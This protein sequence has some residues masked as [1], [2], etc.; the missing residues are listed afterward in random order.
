MFLN[1]AGPFGHFPQEFSSSV[2]LGEEDE[3]VE[4]EEVEEEVGLAMAI[5]QLRDPELLNFGKHMWLLRLKI[6]NG[7][8]EKKC[9]M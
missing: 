2:N 1:M 3:N 4:V 7:K 6:K 8:V 5:K 9:K